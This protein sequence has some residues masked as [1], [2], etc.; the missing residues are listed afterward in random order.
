MSQR[1]LFA[2]ACA[3][4]LPTRPLRSTGDRILRAASGAAIA[5]GICL[6]L[7]ACAG[8]TTPL[9][10]LRRAS[11]PSLSQQEQKEAMEALSRKGNHHADDA[12]REIEGQE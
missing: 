11:A 8:S 3:S 1:G 9:P 4:V 5:F 2:P 6:S 7:T 10:D 12:V